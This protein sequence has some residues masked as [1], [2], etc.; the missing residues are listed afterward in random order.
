MADNEPIIT[1]FVCTY[2]Q[3]KTIERALKSVMEQK[4]SY[5]YVVRI[6]DDCSTDGTTAI[7]KKY[8]DTYPDV[9]E[10]VIQKKNTK[11]GHVRGE[12][13][14]IKTKYWAFLE[15]DD[16][17]CDDTRIQR[18][19]DFLE[20]HE[21]Y[22][23]YATDYLVRTKDGKEYAGVASSGID[24]QN[25]HE[26]V[27]GGGVYI[28]TSARVLRN[29]IDWRPLVYHKCFGDA[30]QMFVCLDK[31][32]WYYENKITTVYDQSEGGGFWSKLDARTQNYRNEILFYEMNKL[33]NFKY[34]GI[35]SCVV[36]RNKLER[37]KK[38]F[39][40]KWGWRLYMACR[41]FSYHLSRFRPDR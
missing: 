29:I 17:W 12:L 20:K 2:N 1:I 28:H 5:K 33:F 36:R 18:A 13:C 3:E 7:C 26:I 23:G 6:L 40:V 8:R 4:I 32:P 39:G 34:D 35:L 30:L 27:L 16:Y 11:A 22:T 31:G 19:L 38:K 21:E 25:L 10:L 41:F 14:S 24:V 9:T 15:G 37:L